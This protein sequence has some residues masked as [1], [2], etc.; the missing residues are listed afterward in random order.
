[1][2]A[3]GREG[4][5]SLQP[6]R[7]WRIGDKLVSLDRLVSAI[8]RMLELRSRGLSQQE[9][10]RMA[11][12]DRTFLSRLESLG[13]LR[14]G[15]RVAVVG[16]P[17]ANRQE[18]EQ[19]AREAGAELVLLLSNEER[20]RWARERSGDQ[21]FNELMALLST[22]SGYD[23]IVFLGSDMRIRLVEALFGADRVVGV[24]L[25]PSP[26]EQDVAVDPQQLAR[27]VRGVKQG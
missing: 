25:G 1:V 5:F 19:A 3:Q 10:A 14:R 22:L 13:E 23:R 24:R 20:W 12:V 4:A 16:F 9:V 18:L 7:L 17:V 2:A 21:V 8:E 11:G 6:G 26:L 27:L 15:E